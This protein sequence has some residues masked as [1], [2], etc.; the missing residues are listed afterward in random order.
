MTTPDRP[1]HHESH[2]GDGCMWWTVRCEGSPEILGV[3]A[4]V[5]RLNQQHAEIERLREENARRSEATRWRSVADELP[6]DDVD[7]VLFYDGRNIDIADK[8]DGVWHHEFGRV[9]M[10]RI[11]HWQP[12]PEP[13][14]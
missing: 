12:L 3:E 9:D 7:E 2:E 11:T 13:P 8:L 4:A 5:E 14:Q 1:Y 10:P 6:P